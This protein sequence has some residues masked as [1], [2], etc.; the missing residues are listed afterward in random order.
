MVGTVLNC[1][2]ILAG[3]AAGLG[4]AAEPLPR[5]C[6]PRSR[7]GWAPARPTS[8]S[9]SCGIQ[10]AG[11]LPEFSA[12]WFCSGSPW[13]SGKSSVVCSAC[14]AP[15]TAWAV[16]PARKWK[17]G[18]AVGE[19]ALEGFKVCAA[20]FCAAPLALLGPLQGGLGRQSLSARDQVVAGR[21][22][23]VRFRGDVRLGN[24]A[25]GPAWRRLQ[26]SVWLAARA[27]SPFCG[28]TPSLIR[29]APPR[30]F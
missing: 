8:A 19:S 16:S 13:S 12:I 15:P 11:V 27:S 6:N 1:V 26:G 10:S 22:G 29:S 28:S 21:L 24:F 2:A 3:G 14:N 5:A 7:S 17:R 18:G 20:L 25:L 30:G 4:A 9:R 23:R